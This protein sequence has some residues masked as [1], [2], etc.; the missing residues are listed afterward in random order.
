MIHWPCILKLDGDDELIYLASENELTHECAGLI[1]TPEDRVI[2][3]TGFVY[4]IVGDAAGVKLVDSHVQLST[5]EV[6]A[7]VQS[8]E[9]CR[10][11]VCLTKIQFGSV[12]DAINGLKPTAV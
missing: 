12:A 7:L 10:A 4:A 3:S 9:F 2:D 5:T 11:E 6:T 1:L 8:H